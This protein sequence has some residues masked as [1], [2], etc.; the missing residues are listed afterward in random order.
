MK[1]TKPDVV[2]VWRKSDRAAKRYMTVFKDIKVDDV[3]EEKRKPLLDNSYVMDEVG[4]GSSFIDAWQ[5]KYKINKYNT[6]K[7]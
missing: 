6:V 2:V 4:V 5:H 3:L 1:E 7:K